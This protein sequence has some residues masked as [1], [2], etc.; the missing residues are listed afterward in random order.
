MATH[1][2][3][4]QTA[5]V[6]VSLL[7]QCCRRL[8]EL[9]NQIKMLENHPDDT[10]AQVAAKGAKEEHRYCDDRRKELM[11]NINAFITS[12]GKDAK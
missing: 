9:D 7:A 10:F 5:H 12:T 4:R 11:A 2:D 6:E 8:G 1:K 3:D